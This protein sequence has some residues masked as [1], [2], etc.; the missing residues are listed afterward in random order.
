ME[1]NK[2]ID[3]TDI[4][5]SKGGR[6]PRY[7]DLLGKVLNLPDGKAIEIDATSY[8]SLTANKRANKDK[9][10]EMAV[11]Q[12]SGRYFALKKKEMA[13]YGL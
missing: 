7:L 12:R 4:P 13:R 8:H 5:E 6:K 2:V 3:I 11:I 1:Y 10:D 9:Y